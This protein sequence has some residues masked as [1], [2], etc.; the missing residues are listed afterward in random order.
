VTENREAH[1]RYR[2]ECA[3]ECVSDAELLIRE[4]RWRSAVNR[5]YYSAFH[6]VSALLLAHEMHSR[7][8]TGVRGLF[9]QH[10]GR[11]G[12]FEPELVKIFNQL[13]DSRLE[14]DYSDMYEVDPEFIRSAIEPTRAF[15]ARAEELIKEKL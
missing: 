1:V 13:F 11:P 5:L 6:A 8:H 3:W 2:L 12:E 14:A 4:E 15:I 9:M 7:K 10:F